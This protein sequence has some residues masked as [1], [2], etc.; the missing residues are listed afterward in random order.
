MTLEHIDSSTYQMRKFITIQ[1]WFIV[2]FKS[3][4][5]ISWETRT[6]K[7]QLIDCESWSYRTCTF[8]SSAAGTVAL[9]WCRGESPVGILVVEWWARN[10][11]TGIQNLLQ[12]MRAEIV[13]IV[14]KDGS[15][16]YGIRYAWNIWYRALGVVLWMDVVLLDLNLSSKGL[17]RNSKLSSLWWNGCSI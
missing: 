14:G 12:R 2:L 4:I 9:A 6:D 17:Q 3:F 16:N 11:V 13:L 1:A 5:A 7:T 15:H 8:H 10:Y